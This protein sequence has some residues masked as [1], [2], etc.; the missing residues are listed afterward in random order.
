MRTFK[1]L[2]TVFC[3]CGLIASCGNEPKNTATE[4]P[5]D[6]KTDIAPTVA[7]VAAE[8]VPKDTSEAS[9]L[10]STKEEISRAE[11]DKIA[12]AAKEDKLSKA[13]KE[14]VEKKKRAKS[15]SSG[16]KPVLSFKKTVHKYGRIS[17]GE[18]IKHNFVFTNTGDSE[19]IISNAK[20]SCGCT[21]P[22]FPFIPIAPG[23]E[24][25]IGVIF[26]S[27]GKIGQQKPMI[28]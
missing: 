4:T 18:K 9:L 7:D 26:D 15:K 14:A 16:D 10:T 3:F 12:L 25:Y 19:L 28:T 20:A 21:Q 11:A 24:G 13:D 6:L 5:A 23:E 1:T 2:A 17:Q 8:P 27:K 22:S